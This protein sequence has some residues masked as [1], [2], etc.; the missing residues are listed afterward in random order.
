MT[1]LILHV[2]PELQVTEGA[3]KVAFFDKEIIKY[4]HNEDIDAPKEEISR[5]MTLCIRIENK[6]DIYSVI[7]RPAQRLRFKDQVRGVYYKHE[8][9]IYKN[10]HAKYI[11]LKSKAPTLNAESELESAKKKIAELEAKALKK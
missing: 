1:N 7:E 5:E 10:A 4:I 3:L 6:E 8:K 2:T 11:E 9:D